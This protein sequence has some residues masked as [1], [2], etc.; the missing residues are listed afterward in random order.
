MWSAC[1]LAILALG[2]GEG[3]LV[4]EPVVRPGTPLMRLSDL[5]TDAQKGYDVLVTFARDP[6]AL[7]LGREV[8]TCFVLFCEWE[9]SAQRLETRTAKAVPEKAAPV[10]GGPHAHAPLMRWVCPP[11][12]QLPARA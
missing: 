11:Q 2:P 1:D 3:S 7:C 10:G 12:R 8:I 9:V 5:S 4:D 6:Y